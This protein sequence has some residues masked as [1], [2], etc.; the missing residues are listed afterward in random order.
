MVKKKV[1]GLAVV[2]FMVTVALSPVLASDLN[3]GLVGYWSFDE[4]AGEIAN[5]LIG[6]NDGALAFGTAWTD[7]QIGGALSF[8]GID[9]YVDTGLKINQNGST[10]ITMSAWVYPTSLKDGKQQIISA[11]N[12][13][14]DWSLNIRN[15]KWQVFTGEGTLITEFTIE[16]NEWQ[17]VVA[18]FDVDDIEVRF[19]INGSISA[20]TSKL[21]TDVSTNHFRFGDNP[22]PWNEYFEGKIDEVSIYDRALSTEDV[23]QLHQKGLTSYDR[24]VA[25][26]LNVLNKKNKKLD[27]INATLGQEWSAFDAIDELIENGGSV[28]FVKR[29]L[30][31]AQS[32]IRLA[33]N[34][35]QQSKDRLEK[36]V[37]RLYVAL[38]ALGLD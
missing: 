7:G 12:G 33:I 32:K 11:D 5:D 29:D 19:Y 36:S 35:E 3:E 25:S 26:I 24:A 22:G 14:F 30:L 16:L 20:V 6:G 8:D 31:F 21:Y 2:I 37:E 9:D 17:H 23:Q 27:E 34:E 1:F 38:E 10:S 4:G 18:V 13:G 28:D 15:G